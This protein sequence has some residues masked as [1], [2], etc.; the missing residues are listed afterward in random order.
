MLSHEGEYQGYFTMMGDSLANLTPCLPPCTTTRLHSKLRFQVPSNDDG[1][2]R[3]IINFM[4]RL[5]VKHKLTIII[6]FF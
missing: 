1:R 2:S 6:I 4:E 5:V 3:V